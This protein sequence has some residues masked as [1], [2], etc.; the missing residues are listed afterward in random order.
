M[1]KAK[2]RF[3]VGVSILA[4]VWCCIAAVVVLGRKTQQSAGILDGLIRCEPIQWVVAFAGQYVSRGML[5]A[6]MFLVQFGILYYEDMHM[7][8][9]HG[10]FGFDWW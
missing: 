9:I 6:P 1:T 2:L 4:T 8:R 5:L 10:K 7:R 3:D